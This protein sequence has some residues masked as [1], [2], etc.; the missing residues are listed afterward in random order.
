[1]V[2]TMSCICHLENVE[3]FKQA[4]KLAFTNICNDNF[5]KLS[6]FENPDLGSRIQ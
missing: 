3:L 6:N 4:N 5:L 1:M 2:S